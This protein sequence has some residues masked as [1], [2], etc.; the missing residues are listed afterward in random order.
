[1]VTTATQQDFF[2]VC[3]YPPGDEIFAQT[4]LLIPL[5]HV[6]EVLTLSWQSITPIPGVTQG[7]LG[8]TNQRGQLIWVVDLRSGANFGAQ[9]ARPNPQEKLTVVLLGE[10]TS[11]R[12]G[13]VVAQLEGVTAFALEPE[14]P[15]TGHWLRFYPHCDRQLCQGTERG[16]TLDLSR[17]FRFLQSG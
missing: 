5:N 1:M 12:I 7:V 8:V 6:L 9:M 2:R 16:F 10:G 15:P 13:L 4:R 17:L 11:Q 3:L 14:T